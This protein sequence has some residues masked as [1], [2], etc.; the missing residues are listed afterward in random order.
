MPKRKPLTPAERAKRAREKR[1]A[2]GL[3]SLAVFIDGR[4]YRRAKLAARKEGVSFEQFATA[5]LAT[6]VA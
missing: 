4:V 5:A 1:A 6:A 2:E 3:V